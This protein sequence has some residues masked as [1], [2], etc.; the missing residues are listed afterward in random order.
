M[1][2]VLFNAKDYFF[3]CIGVLLT[4]KMMS[5]CIDV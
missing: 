3:A 4:L 2:S 5:V 1:C